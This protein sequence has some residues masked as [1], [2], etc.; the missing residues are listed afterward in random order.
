MEVED[1]FMR[2]VREMAI[3]PVQTVRLLGSNL[4][5]NVPDGRQT[6]IANGKYHA[7]ANQFTEIKV[8]HSE[9][10]QYNMTN[11]KDDP[12]GSAAVDKFQGKVKGAYITNLKEKDREH[13]GTSGG[14]RGPLESLFRQVDFR[15]LVFGTFGE[16]N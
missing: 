9:T 15:P 8:I 1:Y 16:C 10:V 3:N 14:N 2:K 5:G 11:V 7:G 4:K 12:Q 13:F 6:E